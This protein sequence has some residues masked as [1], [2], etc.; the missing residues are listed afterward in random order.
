MQTSYFFKA[1]KS[2]KKTKNRKRD[3]DRDSEKVL[4]KFSLKISFHTCFDLVFTSI[5]YLVAMLLLFLCVSV[6][7]LG[8]LI[9]ISKHKTQKCVMA[10]FDVHTQQSNCCFVVV[11]TV[12]EPPKIKWLFLLLLQ[13]LLVMMMVVC[14]CAHSLLLLLSKHARVSALS[15]CPNWKTCF[16]THRF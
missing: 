2:I 11:G 8:L 5:Q 7:K 15:R 9:K 14:A 16:G 3:R 1:Y 12:L 13:S 6:S 10:I 4:N